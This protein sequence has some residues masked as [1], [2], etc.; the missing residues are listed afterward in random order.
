MKRFSFFLSIMALIAGLVALY[1]SV[2]EFLKRRGYLGDDAEDGDDCCC[3][4][5]DCDCDCDCDDEEEISDEEL[6]FMEDEEAEKSAT[7][8]EKK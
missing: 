3:C 7:K 6:N 4:D 2:T 1:I 5:Y 8:E